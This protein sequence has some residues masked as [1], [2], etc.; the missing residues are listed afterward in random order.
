MQTSESFHDYL[1]ERLNNPV[2][3]EVYLQTACEEYREDRD[4]EMFWI[5]QTN[6]IEAGNE[7]IIVK[8]IDLIAS[9]L[10]NPHSERKNTSAISE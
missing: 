9:E 6:I 2:E 8:N 7:E 3:A 10:N 4:L 1:I 5:A